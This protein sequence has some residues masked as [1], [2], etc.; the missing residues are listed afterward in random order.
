MKFY[1]TI[2]RK[3]LLRQRCQIKDLTARPELYVIEYGYVVN[4][5]S[6]K[7]KEIHGTW[8]IAQDEP[9]RCS[10]CAKSPL[11]NSF[12]RYCPNCGARMN[13]I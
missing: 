6:V 2:S 4:A 5:K 9:L 12:E 11:S 10:M 3:D 13:G 1:D 8:L 7:P